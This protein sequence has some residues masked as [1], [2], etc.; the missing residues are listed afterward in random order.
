MAGRGRPSRTTVYSRLDSALAELHNRL[1]GLPS[2]TEAQAI[3]D[4]I[5]HLEAHHST[6]IEG[7]TL[8]LREVQALLDQG[9]AVGSKSLAEYNEVRGYADAAR[10]VYRQ[11]LEPGELFDG[12]L[13]T[14]GEIRQTHH[15]AMTPV[16]DVAP[17]PEATDREGPGNF[18]EHD[19]HPFGGGMKPPTWPL[20]PG[21]VQLW[22]DRVCELGHAIRDGKPL[23]MPL[24]EALAKL[25]NEFER[26]HPFLDGNGRTGRLTLNLILV[27]LGHPPVVIFKRQ[28]AAYLAA[29]QRADIGDY[30]ALGELIARAMY[31]NLNRFIV[32]NIAGPARLVPIASLAD[33]DFSLPALRQAAQ[34]GTLEA[35]QGVDGI[36]RSSRK[37]IDAY[38]EAKHKRRRNP[39]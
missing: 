25:H 22:V 28:R 29:L 18:R 36:W 12:R 35:I 13:V 30:G 15:T 32:P 17:H 9:R 37:A 3:W 19:I 10:W 21:Q 39:A 1:G 38:R 8:V 7:N 5:W 27:R 20:V 23:A 2:P 16:W 34:R 6:A 24:P 31:D 11:A 4:D 33:Q 14:I 26:I